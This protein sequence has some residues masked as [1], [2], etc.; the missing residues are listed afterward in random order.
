MRS[1]KRIISMMLTVVM[2]LGMIPTQTVS[3]L[4]LTDLFGNNNKTSTASARSDDFTLQIEWADDTYKSGTSLNINESKDVQNAATLR[5]NYSC[6][7]VPSGGYKAG[8]LIITVKGIGGVLRSGVQE[9]LVGADKMNS[10]S[11]TH[12]WSYSWNKTNDTYT[13]TNNKAISGGSVLS[14]YFELTWGLQSRNCENG[15]AQNDIS[16]SLYLPDGQSLTTSSLSFSHNTT[17]DQFRL[18]IAEQDNMYGY[19]GLTQDISNPEDY[20]WVKY[21]IDTDV[22]C[23]AR[24]ATNQRLVIDPDAD[25]IGSGAICLNPNLNIHDNKDGTYSIYG[26]SDSNQSF[27]LYIAYPKN[28]Y[29]TKTVQLKVQRIGNWYDETVTNSILAENSISKNIPGDFEFSHRPGYLYKMWLITH[30][31]NHSMHMGDIY[32]PGLQNNYSDYFYMYLT[33][34]ADNQPYT[35][36]MAADNFYITTQND[37]RALNPDEYELT[38]ISI[39]GAGSIQNLNGLPADSSAMTAEIYTAQNGAT[40]DPQNTS[41]DKTVSITNSSQTINLPANTTAVA[42]VLTNITDNIQDVRFTVQTKFHT[43]QAGDNLDSGKLVP[44]AFIRLYNQESEGTKFG[45]WVNHATANDYIDTTELHLAQHDLATYGDY[46]IR[47]KTEITFFG[48]TPDY[49]KAVIDAKTLKQIG[50]YY[51]TTIEVE[52][53][54]VYDYTTPPDDY[55][56]YTIL[57]ARYSL[58]GYTVPEDIY[59]IIKT[60]IPTTSIDVDTNYNNTGLTYI[61]MHFDQ[62]VDGTVSASIPVKTERNDS[63]KV[64]AVLMNHVPVDANVGSQRDD[65]K[66][67]DNPTLYSDLDQNNSLD[68]KLSYDSA[69]IYKALTA[70]SSELSINKYIQSQYSDGFTQSA[71]VE[72]NG[73]YTYQLSVHTGN[74]KA[75]HVVITDILE[76]AEGSEWNGY[77]KS[78]DLSLCEAMGIT[79]TVKYSSSTNPGNASSSSWSTNPNDITSAR[80]IMIDFGDTVLDRGTELNILVHM[81]APNETALK[82]K[83]AYNTFHAD[84]DLYDATRPDSDPVSQALDSSQT[85]AMLTHS[86][87]TI[88]ITK[89]DEVDKTRLEGAVFELYDTDNPEL[90]IATATTNANGYAVF[91]YIPSDHTYILRE[92]QAPSGYLPVEDQTIEVKAETLRLTIQD[93]R[94]PGTIE[95]FKTTSLTSSPLEGAEFAVFDKNTNKQVG[96][97]VFTD[98]QGAATIENLAWGTYYL[99][100]LAAPNG[101]LVSDQTYEFTVTRESV[102]QDPLLFRISNDQEPTKVY[103]LKTNEQDQPLSGAILELVY[104]VNES[105]S[106]RYGL[107]VTDTNGRVDIEDLPYGTYLL[108]EYRAP[109]GYEKFEEYQFTLQPDSPVLGEDGSHTI[110][111][112]A[113]DTR[114]KGSVTIVKNDDIGNQIE[115]IEF[116]LYDQ[117]AQEA[118]KAVTDKAGIAKIENLEWGS[119]ILKETDAPNYYQLNT[120]EYEIDITD[121]NLEVQLT[122]VNATQKGGVVL[123]KYDEFEF[124]TLEGAVYSL[125]SAAGVYVGDFTTGPDGTLTVENLA[126]GGYYFKEKTA[127]EGY[128]LSDETIRFSV[129]ANNSTTVQELTATDKKITSSITVTKTIKADDINFANGNPTFIF[130]VKGQNQNYIA[131]KAIVFDESYVKTNT[132]SD[133]MVS[134][135]IIISE[136]PQDTYEV[137][138]LNTS[139]YAITK[140]TNVTNGEIQENKAI[141]DLRTATTYAIGGSSGGGSSV[142]TEELPTGAVEFINKN[143]EAQDFSHTDLR[144]NILSERQKLTSISVDYEDTSVKAGSSV[145]HDKLTVIANYDDGA[146]RTLNSNEYHLSQTVFSKVNGDYTIT[147]TFEDNGIKRTGNFTVNISDGI[148][149]IISLDAKYTNTEDLNIGDAIT[150]S[151]FTVKA[152]TNKGGVRTLKATEYLVLMSD[153]DINAV[154]ENETNDVRI[155]LN[156]DNG[157]YHVETKVTD[158]LATQPEPI[159]ESGSL[160]NAHIK[161][162]TTAVLF[163]NANWPSEDELIDVSAAKNESV[164]AWY[165]GTTMYVRSKNNTDPVIANQN[166][167]QMFANK[168]K[169]TTVDTTALDLSRVKDM[170]QMF[171]WCQALTTLDTSKWNTSDVEDMSKMFY[172]CQ[173]ITEINV[174]YW[175]VSNVT[176]M[177]DM[178]YCCYMLQT[179]DVSKWDTSS[180]KD[181]TRLFAHCKALTA[182]DVSNWDVSNVKY[183]TEM[184]NECTKIQKLDVTEWNTSSFNGSMSRMF[185]QCYALNEL[186]PSGWDTSSITNMSEVFA[187]AGVINLDL[188]RWNTSNVTNMYRMFYWCNNLTTVDLSN[189]DVSKVTGTNLYSNFEGMFDM[190][191]NLQT[192]NL[193]NWNLVNKNDNT[194]G[195]RDMTSMFESCRSLI[196]VNTSN[197]NTSTLETTTDMFNECEKLQKIDVSHWNTSNLKYAS[198]MF[199]GCGDIIT[200]DVSNW[201]TSNLINAA[202]MFSGCMTIT[203]L[204]VSKWD[205]PNVT[206]MAGMFKNCRNVTALDVARFNTSKVTNMTEMFYGCQQVKSL[207]LLN[208]DTDLVTNMSRMFEF[209]ESLTQLDL[210]SFDT[211]NVTTVSYMFYGCDAVTRAYART[212]EDADK[213]NSAGGNSFVPN[214]HFVVKT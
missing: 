114:K 160:F 7:N 23:N 143:Y 45:A 115:G 180:V 34:N 172:L 16:A 154:A 68:D 141:I 1:L 130:R 41:P 188:S 166:C 44:V 195:A 47:E 169:L 177:G 42:V 76:N 132:E 15:Y 66:W 91:H 36:E 139:R 99:K 109:A 4:S 193:A 86:L 30:D 64:Y 9:A 167:S 10:G 185:Y 59:D 43:N 127:P 191:K 93:P 214:I 186:N 203:K 174:T 173:Q 121:T 144:T 100:E 98:N 60:S 198:S 208:F 72:F 196:E 182:L 168:K 55:T 78:I 200:L 111:I 192:V 88:V 19:Q 20:A 170:S 24:G 56:L 113:K 161:D 184:F 31:Y 135:S 87:E 155:V 37:Y 136:L 162:D 12:D 28:Q 6:M 73:E 81:T 102:E 67:S 199:E 131:Y 79:G 2:L 70:D 38:S 137:S 212:Q 18:N 149:C 90:M 209:D 11:K 74:G 204:D 101:Y 26:L 134:Q 94:K 17:K 80:A 21:Q 89:E 107:Y 5:V 152:T 25:N 150:P 205:T 63:V 165:A 201:K 189:W 187:H 125:Y 117:N 35:A 157:G 181:M 32:G 39:P 3:A 145:D 95:I 85:A 108:K 27:T 104:Q 8:D 83:T 75:S 52:G 96:K 175:D 57:P 40:I 22:T 49:Q 48:E 119:Y 129:N 142:V 54:F 116:T 122:I 138:E 147:V 183:I 58:K 65:G 171:Y 33:V 146:S 46:L 202:Y 194:K 159:L 82:N 118:G 140:I 179:L 148:D 13:F 178:F 77:L 29:A 124:F 112:T 106:F 128:G 92:V 103:I 120:E 61:A 197:W 176:N 62:P 207:N 50:R 110:T 151:M 156:I 71:P 14:G 158:I 213:F 126:W 206:N 97:S 190:C 123:T 153:A 211:T 163:T 210:S 51:E 84:F 53:R 164:I 133:G 69:M 105:S